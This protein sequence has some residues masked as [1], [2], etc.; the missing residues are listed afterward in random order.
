MRTPVLSCSIHIHLFIIITYCLHASCS[1]YTL[2]AWQLL[3]PH[4]C[5]AAAALLPPDLSVI[6]NSRLASLAR[7]ATQLT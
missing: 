3:L 2:Y 5:S 1:P 6:A 4:R 7:L